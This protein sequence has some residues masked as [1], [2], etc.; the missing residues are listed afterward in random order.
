MS[1]HIADTLRA[2]A[3]RIDALPADMPDPSSVET[4]RAGSVHVR[5]SDASANT[6]RAVL[7]ALPGPWQPSETF[8]YRLGDEGDVVR[9]WWINLATPPAPRAVADPAALLAEAVTK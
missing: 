5:W 8:M 9:M 2:A 1:R 7:A 4:S 6:A 3:E